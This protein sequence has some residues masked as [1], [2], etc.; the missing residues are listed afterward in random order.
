[1]HNLQTNSCK[2]KVAWQ[3]VPEHE[4]CTV[5]RSS[6]LRMSRPAWE[7]ISAHNGTAQHVQHTSQN[8]IAY[9]FPLHAKWPLVYQAVGTQLMGKSSWVQ[10]SGKWATFCQTA[11]ISSTIRGL[12]NSV[13]HILNS[14]MHNPTNQRFKNA[15]LSYIEKLIDEGRQEDV[16]QRRAP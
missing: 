2:S 13:F 10:Y 15:H 4:P 6:S 1:M 14:S 11:I 9:T 5:T 3:F 8:C 12:P 16:E 7:Q